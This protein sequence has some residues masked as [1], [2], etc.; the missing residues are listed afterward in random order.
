MPATKKVDAS[1]KDMNFFSEF[2]S[3]STQV[4]SALSIA[5]V[6]FILVFLVA[7]VL[8]VFVLTKTGTTRKEIDVI[9]SEMNSNEYTM[10]LEGYE[11]SSNSMEGLREY[12]Y[13]LTSLQGRM[14]DM[15]FADTK[16]MDSITENIPGEITL[17]QLDFVDGAIHVSGNSATYSAP[18]DMV[19]KLQDSGTFT[20][21]S[22]DEIK[23]RDL[24]GEGMT[25]EEYPTVKKYT[26]AFTGSLESSYSVSVTRFTNDGK[27]TPLASRNVQVYP[28]GES[29]GISG[30]ATFSV[31]AVNYKLA[32]VVINDTA[33]SAEQLSEI[34]TMDAITGRVSSTVDIKLYYD[35]VKEGGDA[36]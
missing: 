13:V 10:A 25:V 3:S 6:L 26:F 1:K 14:E 22:I 9:K 19:A 27:G 34:L 24:M 7:T 30:I 16:Y 23:Q 12:L 21:V 32:K 18:L 17:T 29:Y 8:Y 20:F 4:A 28:V 33:V 31:D 15:L 35:V 5:L 11:K 2:T 36:K